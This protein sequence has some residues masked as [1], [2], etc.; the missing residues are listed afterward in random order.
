M[1]TRRSLVTG[2]AGLLPWGWFGR[3]RPKFELTIEPYGMARLVTY[4][5]KFDHYTSLCK[6]NGLPGQIVF[7]EDSSGAFPKKRLSI[8]FET[9]PLPNLTRWIEANPDVWISRYG[10]PP[11][12]TEKP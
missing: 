10:E 7:Y 8:H 2:L 9:D 4:N 3:K 11:K 1:L 5:H 12:E 6:L